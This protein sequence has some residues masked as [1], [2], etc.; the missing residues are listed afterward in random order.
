PAGT[1]QAILGRVDGVT[2]ALG[3]EVGHEQVDI[4]IIR[5]TVSIDT[6][7]E[8]TRAQDIE[9]ILRN[10][11]IRSNPS[12]QFMRKGRERRTCWKHFVAAAGMEK[13]R[14]AGQQDRSERKLQL[15]A[16]HFASLFSRQ[17]RR[18]RR[19]KM[20]SMASE[21]TKISHPEKAWK[22]PSALSGSQ[23]WTSSPVPTTRRLFAATATGTAAIA[24]R[25]RIIFLGSSKYP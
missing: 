9:N 5:R 25:T 15:R 13:K 10:G 20:K 23:Y 7:Q 22:K 6:Q 18:S 8:L 1:R 16:H 14:G 11:H 21:T 17:S 3:R 12:S 2:R 24:S 19:C 4:R